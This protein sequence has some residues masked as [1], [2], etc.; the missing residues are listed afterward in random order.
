G[1]AP[2]RARHFGPAH[3]ARH[4]SRDER[5][6]PD[7][8]PRPRRAHRGGDAAGGAR[9][10]AC[11]RGL[12]REPKVSAEGEQPA[13]ANGGKPVLEVEDIH[14]FYG[15]IEA[16]KGISLSVGEGEIVTLIG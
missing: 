7:H 1:E 5:V 13:S 14:T 11:D 15:S 12:S 2:H 4:E 6:R 3:R 9:G 16:L 8:R 10:P